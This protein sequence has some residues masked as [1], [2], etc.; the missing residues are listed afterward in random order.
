VIDETKL[1]VI[2]R[3][4]N[5]TSCGRVEVDADRDKI[6]SVIS[7]LINNAI[8]Y[9]PDGKQV[10]VT[11]SLKERSLVVSVQDEGIGIR[12]E[13]R[14]KIFERYY[15]VQTDHTKHISGFGIG[16]YLSAEI[17]KR[18]KGEIWVESERG[19]GS[20]FSFTL[21]LNPDAPPT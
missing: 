11:C 8:K 13:D 18:H 20:K 17:V 10:D 12:P 3:T 5:V 16:L 21:P 4:I 1:T 9:S 19:T 14:E 6:S 2:S 7:N 15:R